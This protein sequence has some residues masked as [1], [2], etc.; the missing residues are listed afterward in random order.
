MIRGL[1]NK[2]YETRSKAP[3]YCLFG[4]RTLCEA[5]VRR[6]EAPPLAELVVG[7]READHGGAFDHRSDVVVPRGRPRQKIVERRHA[8]FALA[9]AMKP[10]ALDQK[11]L[12]D[13][14]EYQFGVERE[15]DLPEV[16]RIR[17]PRAHQAQHVHGPARRVAKKAA[18][19]RVFFHPLPAV[20]AEE[21][22]AAPRPARVG[23]VSHAFAAHDA[24]PEVGVESA[25]EFGH[26]LRRARGRKSGAA[27]GAVL[28]L[29]FPGRA[30]DFS[31]SE[32]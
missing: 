21:L 26:L 12:V 25:S 24:L 5:G 29:Q 11:K 23:A 13:R 20:A 14:H 8:V 30:L 18:G 1:R 17:E 6:K 3:P 19:H 15:R 27:R 16:L 2:V 22:P 9:P 32:F 4:E 7:V 31:E 28:V 10:L